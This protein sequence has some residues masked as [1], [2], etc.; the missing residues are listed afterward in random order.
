MK[1]TILLSAAALVA[2]GALP[3]MSMVAPNLPAERTQGT[4]TYLTGGVGSDVSAAMLAARA[5]YPLALEFVRKAK[6]RDEYLGDVDV[7]IEDSS[8]EVLH[9]TSDGPFLFA[10]LPEG[11]YIVRAEDDGRVK[12]RHVRVAPGKHEQVVFEW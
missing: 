2:A 6:P 8:G 4:V 1:R 9:A 3:A 12:M 7:T 10:R 5:Q 11:K